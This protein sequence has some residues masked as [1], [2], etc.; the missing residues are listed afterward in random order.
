MEPSLFSLE[1]NES[2]G[3]S[4]VIMRREYGYGHVLY[5]TTAK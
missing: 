5:V 1:L 2:I 4:S 3:K